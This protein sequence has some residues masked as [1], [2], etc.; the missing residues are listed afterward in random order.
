MHTHT[1]THTHTHANLLPHT[2]T[3]TH[4]HTHKHTH[5]EPLHLFFVDWCHNTATEYISSE[6]NS[7][8][9]P[10]LSLSPSLSPPLPPSPLSLSLSPSQLTFVHDSV[11]YF[12]QFNLIGFYSERE[13]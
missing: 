4:T 2:H 13:P 11:V 9:P 12:V 10:T 8:T 7:P 5:T 3:H 1:H 6:D